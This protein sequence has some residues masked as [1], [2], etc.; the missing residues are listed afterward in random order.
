[1]TWAQACVRDVT[2][3]IDEALA[4]KKDLGYDY[5]HMGLTAAVYDILRVVQP[6]A[7]AEQRRAGDAAAKAL[8]RDAARAPCEQAA[9]KRATASPNSRGGWPG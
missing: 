8:A 3:W 2:Y 4:K 9:A 5:Q 7:L 1:M 6:Q